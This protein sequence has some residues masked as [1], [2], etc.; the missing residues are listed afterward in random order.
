MT[1]PYMLE[2]APLSGERVQGWQSNNLLIGNK[3]IEDVFCISGTLPFTKA[4]PFDFALLTLSVEK[5]AGSRQSNVDIELLS[6]KGNTLFAGS[7]GFNEAAQLELNPLWLYPKETILKCLCYDEPPN[8]LI[9]A[10]VYLKR[11]ILINL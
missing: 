10:T 9:F 8:S 3:P 4:I 1:S 7:I 6:T 5:P 11:I 2:S